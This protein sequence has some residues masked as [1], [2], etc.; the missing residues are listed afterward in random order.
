MLILLRISFKLAISP[1]ALPKGEVKLVLQL[2][3]K[4][5]RC[6]FFSRR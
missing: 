6:L 4:W 3:I 1:L 5:F 2:N